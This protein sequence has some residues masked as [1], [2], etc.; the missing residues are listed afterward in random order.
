MDCAEFRRRL[1]VE[2]RDPA[3]AEAAAAGVHPQADD[4]LAAALD[5]E[6]RLEQAVRVEP[7]QD[8]LPAIYAALDRETHSQQ[9][10]PQPLRAQPD[11]PRRRPWWPLALAASLLSA[12]LLLGWPRWQEAPTTALIALGVD[13]LA[14]EPYALTRSGRVP[15]P[16]VEGMLRRA[17]LE[18]DA[19]A[20]QLSYL[21]RC[22][23]G[24]H[25][26][27]H[28]VVQAEAGPVTL[29]YVLQAGAVER[30]DTRHAAVA[31][32]AIP[33]GEGALLLL[34]ED[35]RDFDRIELDWRRAVSPGAAL[36]AASL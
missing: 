4:E 23:L 1:L 9:G 5:F 32:R 21:S 25:W 36:A 8:L 3:L 35:S 26:S 34:A 7:P 31:V 16:L 13:H 24:E 28:M 17:G 29:L 22:P 14:H 10:S 30:I 18:V 6:Q 15:P 27:V 11:A 33:Q 20:L 19:E 2:P 12:A